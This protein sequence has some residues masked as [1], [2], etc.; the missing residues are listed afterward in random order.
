MGYKFNVS[1]SPYV[2]ISVCGVVASKQMNRFESVFLF[3]NC[4]SRKCFQLHFMAAGSSSR[5]YEIIFTNYKDTRTIDNDKAYS[6]TKIRN[7]NAM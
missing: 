6:K 3:E 2:S 7:A 1:V 4:N 5:L